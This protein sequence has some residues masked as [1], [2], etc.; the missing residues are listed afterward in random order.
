M[1]THFSTQ[2]RWMGFPIEIHGIFEDHSLI[3]V[4]VIDLIGGE[5]LSWSMEKRT[6]DIGKIS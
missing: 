3:A 2:T 4:K 5:P 6:L 1:R